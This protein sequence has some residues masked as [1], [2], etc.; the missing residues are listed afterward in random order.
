MTT[1][2]HPKA[3]GVTVHATPE[4]AASWLAAGWRETDPYAPVPAP[5]PDETPT[6]A[7]RKRAAKNKE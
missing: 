7:P 3:R 1:L 5:V 2:Y 4:T 6:P